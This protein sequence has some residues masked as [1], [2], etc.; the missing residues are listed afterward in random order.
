MTSFIWQ[1]FNFFLNLGL[2]FENDQMSLIGH[3]YAFRTGK[4]QEIL[5]ERFRKKPG[6]IFSLKKK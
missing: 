2:N 6:R 4:F 1:I 3:T 5:W